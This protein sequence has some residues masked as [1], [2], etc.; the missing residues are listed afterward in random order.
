MNDVANNNYLI[1]LDAI[2]F[3]GLESLNKDKLQCKI[4]SNI[5]E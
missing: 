3:H 4:M 2:L 5:F 1:N